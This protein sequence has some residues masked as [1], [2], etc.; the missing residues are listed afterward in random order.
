MVSAIVGGVTGST[1]QACSYSLE[2]VCVY[3]CACVHACMCVCVCVRVCVS[4]CACL[5]IFVLCIRSVTITKGCNP[6]FIIM[7]MG[8]K[9]APHSEYLSVS[10]FPIMIVAAI[11]TLSLSLSLSHFRQLNTPFCIYIYYHLFKI[12]HYTLTHQ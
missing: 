8:F 5:C 12:P 4:V 11:V 2:S 7:Y 1:G 9:H 3:V 6:V 10:N